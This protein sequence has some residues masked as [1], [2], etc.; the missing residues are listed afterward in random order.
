MPGPL[1]GIRVLDLTW[2]L[3]G[4][5][6]TMILA[7]LGAEVIKVERPPAGDIARENGPFVADVS[8]YFFSINR[9]KRSMTL[10]LKHPEGKRL[11]RE[12]VKH[13]DVL[14]ENFV[15]GTMDRLGLGYEVLKSDNPRLIYAATS[16]FGQTG[17]YRSRP[18]M[19]VIVQGISG[20]MS[21]TGPEGGPPVRVGTSVGDIVA[22]MFTAIGILAALQ[23]RER[24]GL[25]Q[26]IDVAMLDSQIAIL[27]NALVRYFVA[28]ELPKPLG[29]RH[30]I[31]T[32]FQA[33][34]TK[35]GYIVLTLTGGGENVWALFCA[36]IGL[37]DYMDDPRFQTN[38]SRTEH[39]AELERLVSAALRERT[40]AEWLAEF[41]ELGIPCGPLNTIAEAVADPQVNERQMIVRIEHPRA[42]AIPVSG[43]PVKL[44]RTPPDV[45]R[46]APDLGADTEAILH[47]LLGLTDDE[48][49]RLRAAG[50][51]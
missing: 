14:T 43:S 3:S 35:D 47:D 25:G 21:I 29:T 40:T 45:S 8:S 6:G 9:G 1:A 31:L 34:P 33:F 7:D 42:G 50:V 2:A 30:P 4:P 41:E 11:L 38:A 5:Y 16:G 20:L 46:P 48:I 44:S 32:P 49:T 17:P 10:N 18:A 24:S 51:L 28:G 15:P 13:V 27:E 19:D 39:H 26:M 22:G 23:E 37:Y 36:K 12:L